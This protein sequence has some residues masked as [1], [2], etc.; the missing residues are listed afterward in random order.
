MGTVKVRLMF[1]LLNFWIK[2][3]SMASSYLMTGRYIPYCGL[4]SLRVIIVL[5]TEPNFFKIKKGTREN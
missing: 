1:L 4:N 2:A 3:V 5:T